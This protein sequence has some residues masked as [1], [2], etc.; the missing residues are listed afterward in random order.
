[1]R[2]KP[3]R[4]RPTGIGGARTSERL[5]R[6][7]SFRN[8]ST[9]YAFRLFFTFLTR[10]CRLI[11]RRIFF[12]QILNNPDGCSAYYRR[13]N[14]LAPQLG[15]EPQNPP[16]QICLGSKSITLVKWSRMTLRSSD[17]NTLTL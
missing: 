3:T 7:A 13:H 1:M 2:P 14:Q 8:L 17:N 4:L 9:F 12:Q 11:H 15:S 16:L 5:R 10:Q 6:P